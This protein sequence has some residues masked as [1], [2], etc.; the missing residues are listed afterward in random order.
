MTWPRPWRCC[1]QCGR[2]AAVAARQ[3]LLR[4]WGH[5]SRH[6]RRP[7]SLHPCPS[8]PASSAARRQGPL[9]RWRSC[10]GSNRRSA[11]QRRSRQPSS[12]RRSARRRRSPRLRSGGRCRRRCQSCRGGRRHGRPLTTAGQRRP[13]RSPQ[14]CGPAA[15]AAAAP[16]WQPARPGACLWPRPQAASPPPR[17]LW[18]AEAARRWPPDARLGAAAAVATW[19]G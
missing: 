14:R 18:Q 8:S 12:S 2:A 13:S 4:L 1:L 7:R 10:S 3:M 16:A 9:L 11:P 5:S 19:Q 17:T 6:P 15:E